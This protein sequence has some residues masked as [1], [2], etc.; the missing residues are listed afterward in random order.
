MKKDVAI[1]V[2]GKE[3]KIRFDMNNIVKLE[4]M[5]GK[6]ISE[7]GGTRLAEVR[8]MVFCTISPQFKKLEDAGNWMDEMLSEMTM[9]EFVE[10]MTEAMTLGMGKQKKAQKK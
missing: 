3:Y 5:L 8:A 6:G 4:E 10:K 7:I 1:T 9:D 2:G